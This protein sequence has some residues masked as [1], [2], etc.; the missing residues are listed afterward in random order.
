MRNIIIPNLPL[1]WEGATRSYVPSLDL[2]PA[3]KHGKLVHVTR[4]WHRPEEFAD[5]IEAVRTHVINEASAEDYVLCVGD[6]VLTAA[7]MKFMC[8]KF[9][10]VTLM[11]WDRVQRE[12]EITEVEL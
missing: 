11:R 8:E 10:K 12:Y 5:G 3:S 9:G 2:N 4:G 6:V 1:R 7:A